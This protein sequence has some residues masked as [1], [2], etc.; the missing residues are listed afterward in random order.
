MSSLVVPPLLALALLVSGCPSTVASADATQETPAADAVPEAP[1]ADVAPELPTPDHP[2]PDVGSDASVDRPL[3]CDV[4]QRTEVGV[5]GVV[6][7]FL[8]IETEPPRVTHCAPGEVCCNRSGLG[9]CQAPRSCSGPASGAR[10]LVCD[11]PEDCPDGGVC[12]GE[13]CV[14]PNHPLIHLAVPYCHDAA[15]CPCDLPHCC[16]DGFFE[17]T[18]RGHLWYCR[19]RCD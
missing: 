2:A 4:P 3:T 5:V 9:N 11:G 6:C 16:G 10:T 1:A 18:T 8:P 7:G 14:P 13:L 17:D 12:V 19:A 15:D